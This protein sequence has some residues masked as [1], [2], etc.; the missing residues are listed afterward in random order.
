MPR[1]SDGLAGPVPPATLQQAG[2]DLWTRIHRSYHI[3][4]AAELELL[5]QACGAADRVAELGEKIRAEG[6][7]VMS[8]SGVMKPNPHLSYELAGRQFISKTLRQL[9]LVDTPRRPVGRP[10][11]GIGWRGN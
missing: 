10:S 11:E 2:I 1:K 3:T 6:V 7:T 8:R 4:D 5:A 9:G